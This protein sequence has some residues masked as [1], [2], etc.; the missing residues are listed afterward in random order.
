MFL[1]HAVPTSRLP[2]PQQKKKK[3]NLVQKIFGAFSCPTDAQRTFREIFLLDALDHPNIVRLQDFMMST[4]HSEVCSVD[5][6]IVCFC[7]IL[8]P[9][10]LLVGCGC[11]R[12]CEA[13]ECLCGEVWFIPLAPR[14]R[15]R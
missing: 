3:K 6:F 14:L 1:L 13:V 5:F 8:C 11:G 12:G 2:F 7:C 15:S 4:V 10:M 9:L